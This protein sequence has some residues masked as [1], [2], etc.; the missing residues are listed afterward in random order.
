MKIKAWG[1]CWIILLAGVILQ[2]PV[3]ADDGGGDIVF[4]DT[5]RF[6]PVLFSHQKHLSAGNQ[7]ADCHDQIFQKKKGSTDVN[8]ALTMKV[9][10][11]GK[12]CGSCHNGRKAFSVRKSCKKCHVKGE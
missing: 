11:K 6:A 9:M 7:C 2:T 10:K 1:F 8:N 5:R 4:K 3:W 12:Y